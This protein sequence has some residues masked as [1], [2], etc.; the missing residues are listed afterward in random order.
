M[1]HRRHARWVSRATLFCRWTRGC[2]SGAQLDSRFRDVWACCMCNAATKLACSDGDAVGT[3][4]RDRAGRQGLLDQGGDVDVLT[5][6]KTDSDIIRQC[7]LSTGCLVS[8]KYG[9]ITSVRI[10]PCALTRIGHHAILVL[11]RDS[12]GVPPSCDDALRVTRSARTRGSSSGH[13][14]QVHARV[15][16][17]GHIWAHTHTHTSDPDSMRAPRF[18]VAGVAMHHRG[19]AL[20]VTRGQSSGLS[21][22]VFSTSILERPIRRLSACPS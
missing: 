9:G 14:I 2:G 6:E 7:T 16:P 12:A 17:S 10:D 20:S 18:R 15:A 3:T 5:R 11:T 4:R 8:T 13:T 22:S 21:M 1:E 19:V